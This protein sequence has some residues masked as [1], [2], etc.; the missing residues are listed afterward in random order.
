V[1]RAEQLLERAAAIASCV[2]PI[3]M[4]WIFLVLWAG[5]KAH[6]RTMCYRMVEIVD[7]TQ[8]CDP[9]G[10]FE[11]LIRKLMGAQ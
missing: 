5:Q 7:L 6:D 8:Q 11:R 10:W 4:L 2:T 3:L 1:T 9:P